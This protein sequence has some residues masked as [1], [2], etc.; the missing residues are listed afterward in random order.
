MSWIDEYPHKLYYQVLL[1][2][3]KMIDWKIGGSKKM[4]LIGV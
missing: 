3:N 4:Y 1:L 2:D